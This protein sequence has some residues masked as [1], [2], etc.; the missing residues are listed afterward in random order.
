MSSASSE[1]DSITQ[2]IFDHLRELKKR[3]VVSCLAI[4]VCSVLAYFLYEPIIHTLARPFEMVLGKHNP[5][6]AP[7]LY[8]TSLF[9]GF[10]TRIKFSMVGGIVLAFPVLLYQL[11]QFV[12]PALKKKEKRIISACLVASTLLALFSLFLCYFFL[13]PISMQFLINSDFIPDNV[14]VMLHFN[15]NIFYVFNFILY[16]MLAF[17]FP[18]ILE[19]LLYFNI[20]S[21]QSL[22]KSSRIVVVLIFVISAIVTPP[23]W[24]SQLGVAIPMTVL[25]YITIL[26]AKIFKWGEP[27]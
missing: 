21:R 2:T 7:V 19:L 25:F 22:L 1:T 6:H 17:Q 20:V 27:Q 5:S 3:L 16:S 24:I 4:M 13:V 15:Q 23:D 26:I 8:V 12:F 9:E 11:I 10:L 18:I 14:G